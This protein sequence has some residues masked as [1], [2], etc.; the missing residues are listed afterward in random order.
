MVISF[1]DRLREELENRLDQVKRYENSIDK[2][3]VSEMDTHAIL[4]EPVLE[5]S[6]W[7]IYNPFVVKRADRSSKVKNIQFDIECYTTCEYGNRQLYLAI[8]VKAY[9][10]IEFNID[11]IRKKKIGKLRKKNGAYRNTNRD[12]VGQLRQYCLN[13]TNFGTAK[14]VLTNG[15]RWV[16]FKGDFLNEAKALEEGVSET[17]C[18]VYDITKPNKLKR[19]LQTIKKTG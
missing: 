11:N 14:P 18:E 1:I 4:V 19:L 17:D 7:N 9:S 5:A 16:I 10:S 6:G 3:K 13:R 8:E 2:R 12:G 15:Q